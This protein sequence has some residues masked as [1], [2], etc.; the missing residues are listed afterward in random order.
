MFKKGLK[1]SAI[2][3]KGYLG[4]LH[5]PSDFLCI[6][7]TQ[8]VKKRSS[9]MISTTDVFVTCYFKILIFIFRWWY[10]K[11]EEESPQIGACKF[12]QPSQLLTCSCQTWNL[13]TPTSFRY[14]NLDLILMSNTWFFEWCSLLF[15][16][17]IQFTFNL[18]NSR[19]V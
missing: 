9:L 17:I 8:K 18:L 13:V 11:K 10:C 2:V 19:Y 5:F 1:L 7:M 4:I 6:P 15:K 12:R 3:G 14:Q 16:Q